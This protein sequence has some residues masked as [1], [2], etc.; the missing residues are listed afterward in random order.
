MR[1]VGEWN[2]YPP[3]QRD[4]GMWPN[5]LQSQDRFNSF[6]QN[7]T[8]FGLTTTT[9]SLSFPPRS[10]SHFEWPCPST[11]AQ[12]IHYS[13]S[14][15]SSFSHNSYAG[16]M[17]IVLHS[18]RL[19]AADQNGLLP[20]QHF[21]AGNKASNVKATYMSEKFGVE[22]PSYFQ[23]GISSAFYPGNSPR[24]CSP[25]SPN[26]NLLPQKDVIRLPNQTAIEEPSIC[27][28]KE[29]FTRNEGRMTYTQVLKRDYCLF[30]ARFHDGAA[31]ATS[32][33]SW[34]DAEFSFIEN[35]RL[36]YLFEPP[37]DFRRRLREW[38]ETRNKYLS[39]EDLSMCPLDNL[40]S[41]NKRS[42]KLADELSTK[43]QRKLEYACILQR[44]VKQSENI[45]ATRFTPDRHASGNE[46]EERGNAGGS[47]VSIDR[48][49][50]PVATAAGTIVENEPECGEGGDWGGA[51]FWG[52]HKARTQQKVL[53]C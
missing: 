10:P 39:E 47:G 13:E 41:S 3:F 5:Q 50:G 26:L 17:P 11:M 4:N 37:G 44:C 29:Y 16:N 33:K 9:N 23:Q 53:R 28:R 38:W 34:S 15:C 6:C 32:K 1:R 52:S 19:S 12:Q 30:R 42:K 35:L 51:Q 43:G 7:D 27:T 21:Q 14:S 18:V 40:F 22:F 25:S 49:S 24:Q 20:P 45:A 8:R 31:A 36:H 48:A 2:L 46:E